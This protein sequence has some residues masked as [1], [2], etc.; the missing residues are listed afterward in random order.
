[1]KPGGTLAAERQREAGPRLEIHFFAVSSKALQV[2]HGGK[3]DA[4]MGGAGAD[5]TVK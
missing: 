3:I 5:F 2:R 4:G 1:M